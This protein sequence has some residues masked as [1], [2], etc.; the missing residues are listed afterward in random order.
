M[1]EF[2]PRFLT[3]NRIYLTWEECDTNLGKFKDR[4]AL[5]QYLTE[6]FPDYPKGKI[7]NN[8]GQMWPFIAEMKKDDWV[9]LPSKLKRAIHIG[10]ITGDYTYTHAAEPLYRHSRT[11]KW[12]ETDI[13]RST[14]DPD[15]LASLGAFMTICKISRNDAEKRIVAM[16]E[17]GWTSS[18]GHPVPPEYDLEEA[19]RDQI[20]KLIIANFK[21]YK[22]ARLVNSI[23]KADGYVTY[24]SQ[25][26]PDKGID[27]LAAQGPLGFGEPRICVQ[28]KSSDSPLDRPTLDQLVGVMSHVKANF[29]LLVSW[30][31]FK[32]SIDREE[33][34]RFFS[35]RLWDQKDLIDQLLAHYDK[36]EDDVRAKLPLKRIWT[37]ALKEEDETD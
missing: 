10:K 13:P 33:A 7:R 37:V 16:S 32:S 21:G 3:E 35:V 24:E 11:V 22:M 31:G 1:G 12:L 20:A 5:T 30:G 28:V 27:I 4:K 36:L 9:I 26:G 34:N 18:H 19:G 2:E 8:S 23:L 29:G 17:K 25:E 6:T 15:I 14:F